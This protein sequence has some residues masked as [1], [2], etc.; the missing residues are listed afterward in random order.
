MPSVETEKR[1]Q[2]WWGNLSPSERS[3]TVTIKAATLSMT[4]NPPAK[5][6][7]RRLASNPAWL[8]WSVQ[9]GLGAS[10]PVVGC[11]DG[12]QNPV[13]VAGDVRRR[14]TDRQRGDRVRRHGQN[15]EISKAPQRSRG[16]E[17]ATR[18]VSSEG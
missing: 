15:A 18:M 14:T 7:K 2:P 17:T 5:T 3:S 8:A 13:G 1:F 16:E 11:G 10:A 6:Q 9:L 12:R 4:R